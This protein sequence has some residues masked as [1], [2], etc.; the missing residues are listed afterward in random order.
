[1]TKGYTDEGYTGVFT[2]L[3]DLGSILFDYAMGISCCDRKDIRMKPED[4]ID[5]IEDA[6]REKEAFE[7]M[8]E[9]PVPTE[10]FVMTEK[11]FNY[12][13]ENYP[14]GWTLFDAFREGIEIFSR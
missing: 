14:D 7:A 2:S 11:D 10:H 8:F 1:M 12:M 13:E 3:F 6:K 9:N 4:Q 5:L